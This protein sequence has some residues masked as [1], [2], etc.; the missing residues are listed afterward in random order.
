MVGVFLGIAGL[1][2]DA[3]SDLMMSNPH[4]PAIGLVEHKWNKSKQE[5]KN[6]STDLDNK[7]QTVGEITA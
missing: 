4:L 6:F 1:W 7:N 3:N 5:K 2:R